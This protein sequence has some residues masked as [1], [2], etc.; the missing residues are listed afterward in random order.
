MNRLLISF[1]T[2]VLLLG[3]VILA[4]TPI[5][6]TT[7]NVWARGF[8]VVWYSSSNEVGFVKSGSS[9]S[10]MTVF[11]DVRGNVSSRV[12]MVDVAGNVNST[13]V[14]SVHSGSVTDNNNGSFYSCQTAPNDSFATAMGAFYMNHVYPVASSVNI[15]SGD[16]FVFARIRNA[17]TGVLSAPRLFRYDFTNGGN[18]PTNQFMYG[19]FRDT[20]GNYLYSGYINNADSFFD[21]R[22]V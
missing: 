9:P 13:Y 21:K 22:L 12:H 15:S 17:L 11:S 16:I 1:L 10:N 7:A 3:G 14:F 2:I 5:Q 18:N 4:D 20:L 6:I 19:T 8:T